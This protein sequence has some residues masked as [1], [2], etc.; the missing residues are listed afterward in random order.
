MDPVPL[1]VRTIPVVAIARRRA[2]TGTC[3]AGVLV[4]AL[5]AGRTTAWSAAGGTAARAG[6]IFTLVA[7]SRGVS[8]IAAE[9]LRVC[10]LRAESEKRQRR[11]DACCSMG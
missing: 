5:A 7:A 10:G 1:A 8:R 2:W 4:D 3:P 11:A 6:S 9:A